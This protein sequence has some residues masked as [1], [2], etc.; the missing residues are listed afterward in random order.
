MLSGG[1]LGFLGSS[2]PSLLQGCGLGSDVVAVPAGVGSGEQTCRVVVSSDRGVGG[3][4]LDAPVCNVEPGP[5]CGGLFG[6]VGEFV[7]EVAV[8]AARVQEGLPLNERSGSLGVGVGR[9]LGVLTGLFGG[10]DVPHLLGEFPAG[11]VVGVLVE[12][13]GNPIVSGMPAGEAGGGR[14]VGELRLDRTPFLGPLAKQPFGVPDVGAGAGE[15]PEP[16]GASFDGAGGFGGDGP[17]GV[18][19]GPERGC[20][21]LGPLLE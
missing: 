14:G 7:G 4:L 13:L 17:V 19:A 8:A 6:Q 18:P 20:D 3:A 2:V 15:P 12:P 10:L 16:A 11:A 5:G 21:L 9:V 1:F